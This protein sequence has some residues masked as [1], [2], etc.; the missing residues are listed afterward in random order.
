MKK[1]EINNNLFEYYE[2]SKTDRE[3]GISEIHDVVS[4]ELTFLG[5]VITALLIVTGFLNYREAKNAAEKAKETSEKADKTNE[6]ANKVIIEVNKQLVASRTNIAEMNNKLIEYDKSVQ[7]IKEKLSELD[8]IE[9]KLNL[10][11]EKSKAQ[12]S[13]DLDVSIKIYTKIINKM[14]ETG[15]ED[16]YIFYDRG[17]AYL[18]KFRLEEEIAENYKGN[19]E[20][21]INNLESIHKIPNLTRWNQYYLDSLNRKAIKDFKEF[22]EKN[23]TDE[24]YTKANLKIIEC[25]IYI[26]EYEQAFVTL[27]NVNKDGTFNSELISKVIA[28]III[29]PNVYEIFEK[30]T[31]TNTVK[32]IS[33]YIHLY[34]ELIFEKIFANEFIFNKRLI[35]NI[36]NDKNNS[37]KLIDNTYNE[38]IEKLDVAYE[39]CFKIRF[40]TVGL[41]LKNIFD[42]FNNLDKIRKGNID[43]NYDSFI[44]FNRYCVE[45]LSKLDIDR[46]N[47]RYNEIKDRLTKM[48]DFPRLEPIHE[49]L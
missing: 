24:L 27:N 39:V 8:K 37:E 13:N 19:I 41:N 34:S 31:D 49:L 9:N 44:V 21:E 14:E 17:N 20:V 36:I 6:K 26:E 32:N 15:D 33:Y 35:D 43:I 18:S 22:L 46:N 38:L 12:T 40:D 47:E 25:S 11:V 2:K 3:T 29:E 7:N 48:R 1:D 42:D 45:F 28:L 10:Y 4:D 23:S 5:I 30:F 16:E